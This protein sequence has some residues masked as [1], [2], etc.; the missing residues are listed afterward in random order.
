M[1]SFNHFLGLSTLDS[2]FFI[3]SCCFLI[4]SFLGWNCKIT[5]HIGSFKVKPLYLVIIKKVSEC[6]HDDDKYHED[7]AY[8]DADYDIVIR[9]VLVSSCACQHLEELVSR[10]DLVS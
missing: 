1:I 8:T 4:I 3:E 9:L 7:C 10:Y 5:W 6:L 2:R